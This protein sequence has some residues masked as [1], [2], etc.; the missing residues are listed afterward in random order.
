MQRTLKTRPSE[1]GD[2]LPMNMLPSDIKE[3][4]VR[5]GGCREETMAS[6][7]WPSLEKRIA[8]AMTLE[9]R[10]EN[11][12]MPNEKTLTENV[13]PSTVHEFSWNGSGGRGS[14]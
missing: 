4:N 9:I 2:E 5:S 1:T 6:A 8:R 11:E 13:S 7:D 12:G 10:P 14:K 3:K